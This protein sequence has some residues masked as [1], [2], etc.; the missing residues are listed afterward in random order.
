MKVNPIYKK[1]LKASSRSSRLPISLMVFN[2]ILAAAALLNMYS[3]LYRVWTTAEIQYTGFLEMY[4]FVTAVEFAMLLFLMPAIAAGSIS[5][6]RER[7]TLDLLLSTQTTP[8]QI[9][10]GKMMASL[11]N[12]FLILIAS[13]PVIALVFVYGGINWKDLLLLFSHFVVTALLVAGIGLFCSALCKRTI[14]SAAASYGGTFLLVGGTYAVNEFALSISTMRWNSYMNQIGSVANQ[15]SSGGFL[16]LMLLNPAAT[17]YS[18]IRNQT[19]MNSVVSTA[20]QWFGYH[21][22]SW[23]TGHW[24]FVSIAVQLATAL[25]F[26]GAAEKLIDPAMKKGTTRWRLKHPEHRRNRHT[27]K[28]A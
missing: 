11:S 20:S 23:I 5:G 4:V 7:Q 13:F 28:D 22:S 17:F 8:K 15:A 27:Q 24:I 3:V 19:G 14:L 1:E 9:I 2:G 21:E 18:I 26:I 10:R 12:M 6:E 25:L 16:Y